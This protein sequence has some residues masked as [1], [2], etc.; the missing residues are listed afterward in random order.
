[1]IS[2]VAITKGYEHKLAEIGVRDSKLLTPKRRSVLF[3]SIMG[4]AAEVKTGVITPEEINE[5]M[6]KGISLNELEAVHFARLFDSLKSDV[7]S[8]YIDSPDV[9]AEK[10]GLRLKMLSS[11]QTRVVGI[12]VRREELKN[13]PVKLIAE[14][15]AD[16]RYPVVSAASIIAK[17][18]RDDEIKKLERKLRL[19]IG[20]GYP[21]DYV[22]IDAVRQH[23]KTGKLSGNLRLHWKTMENIKQ[24]KMDSFF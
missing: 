24:T 22:T 23:L 8:F 3:N 17:V 9:I 15:K 13:R 18:T 21:S 20:S 19:K 6:Q 4:I 5:A 7:K 2:I 16:V 12:K 14:H 1:V 10:F 11:K